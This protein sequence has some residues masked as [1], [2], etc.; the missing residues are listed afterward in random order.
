[1]NQTLNS[2]FIYENASRLHWNL[3]PNNI[4]TW[5]LLSKDP[6]TIIKCSLYIKNMKDDKR[7]NSK[8][9]AKMKELSIKLVYGVKIIQRQWKRCIA[10]PEYYLCKRRLYREFEELNDLK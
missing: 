8:R 7:Q 4:K 2:K 3:L 10:N 1:M 5:R 9:I 6:L